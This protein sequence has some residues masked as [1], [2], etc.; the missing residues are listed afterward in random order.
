MKAN[1]SRLKTTTLSALAERLVSASKSGKYSLA[2]TENPL[3]IALETEYKAYKDL[4]NK[5]VYSGKGK[6][7]AEADEARDKAF[8]AIKTYLKA[9]AGLTLLPHYSDAVALYE[10]FKQNDLNLDQ[11]SY[12]DQSVLLDKLISELDKPENKE[13]LNHLNLASAF[14]DLKRKQEVF[15]GLI[16]QQ[17][18]ANTE[19]R[20]IKSASTVRKDLER[21]IRDYLGFI[22]AMK[23]QPDY[24]A[25][26]TELNEVVKEIRNS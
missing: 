13:K 15:S 17:T 18:E 22:T 9:F 3:L 16:S 8:K 2:I 7:V 20:L 12:A 21:A 4:V 23:S 1:I 14:A 19:L 24:Q 10:V 26:Y 6:E 11:K 25:P 5:Q